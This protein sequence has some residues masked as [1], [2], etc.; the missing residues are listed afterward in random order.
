MRNTVNV[1]K[2]NARGCYL[3][4]IGDRDFA[5]RIPIPSG[6]DRTDERVWIEHVLVERVGQ[7]ELEKFPW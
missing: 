6:R 4:M 2:G 3:T 1:Q 5:T 7:D